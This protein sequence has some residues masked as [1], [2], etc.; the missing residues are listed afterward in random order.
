M[1]KGLRR[2]VK[3]PRASSEAKPP[4]FEPS[5]I[6]ASSLDRS[7]SRVSEHFER[8]L[9]ESERTKRFDDER[10]KR[11]GYGREELVFNEIMEGVS[12]ILTKHE[13]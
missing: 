11:N 5:S 4:Q 8:E 3:I 10:G 6:L 2:V 7:N 13:S 9:D 12:V 1:E